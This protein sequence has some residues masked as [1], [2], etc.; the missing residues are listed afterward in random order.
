M[1][2]LKTVANTTAN[3]P[4]KKKRHRSPNY[5]AEGLEAAINRVRKLYGEDH[6]AGF[7]CG[8]GSNSYRL[9]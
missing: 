3:L 1:S 4:D 7:K 5:P 2:T 6:E 8:I 9:H